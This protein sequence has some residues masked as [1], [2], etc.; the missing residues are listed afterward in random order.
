MLTQ[1]TNF[2][3]RPLPKIGEIVTIYTGQRR[4]YDDR[5][6]RKWIVVAYPLNDNHRPDGG[7]VYSI[8]IHTAY[9]QPLDNR[10]YTTRCSAI[11][12]EPVGQ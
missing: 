11:Y 3:H 10:K 8:G 1:R 7:P 6:G 12:M 4:P 2:H 9:V 5:P